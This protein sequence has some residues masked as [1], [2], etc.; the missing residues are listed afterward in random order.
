[1]TMMVRHTWFARAKQVSCFLHLLT[2]PL[3][4]LKANLILKSFTYLISTERRSLFT[5]MSVDVSMMR[6]L[7]GVSIVVPPCI[8][9]IGTTLQELN[10]VDSIVLKAKVSTVLPAKSDSDVTFCLQSYQ[11]PIIDRSLVY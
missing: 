6:E 10:N 11:G 3:L 5:P 8:Q 2:N 9:S 1:M 4:R 7:E